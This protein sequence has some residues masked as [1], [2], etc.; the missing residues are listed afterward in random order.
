MSLTTLLQDHNNV[1]L[2]FRQGLEPVEGR[3]L[4]L[5]PAT[6]PT[7]KG[8][9][10]R[11]G[12]PYTIN[13]LRD[14]TLV[15]CLDSVQSQANRME[16]SFHG[17]LDWAVPQLAVSAG[18]R[19]VR[20]TELSH[21]LADAAIRC[22]SL[23]DEIKAAFTAFA[24]GDPLAIAR[25]SPTSLVYGAWDSRET[26]VKIPRIIRSEIVAYDVD[27]FTR[28][29]Q[30]SGSFTKDELDFSDGEWKKGAEIG[31]APTPSVDQHGGVLVRGRIVQVASIHIGAVRALG[32]GTQGGRLGEYVLALALGGL[33]VGGRDYKLRSGCWLVPAEAPQTEVVKADGGRSVL[34]LT[35]KD[36]D[37][38]LREAV[39]AAKALS[40][41]LPG[42]PGTAPRVYPYDPKAGKR[43]L[44]EGKAE[45]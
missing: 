32:R 33:F 27:P 25:L 4:P 42:G 14:G 5:F 19:T 16:E 11:H 45:E 15:A 31:F 39:A 24:K 7:P 20:L 30:F 35:D 34:A 29:A 8:G 37:A 9:E 18:E 21:R 28:S 26:Q 38:L 22:T 44:K 41:D 10:H 2:T 43:L 13:R 40:I 17:P 12:T 1:A 3:D 36:V 6:Y 23:R